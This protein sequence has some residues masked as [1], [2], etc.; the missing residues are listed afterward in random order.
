MCI[1]GF[2]R[3]M[4]RQYRRCRMCGECLEVPYDRYSKMEEKITEK[5]LPQKAFCDSPPTCIYA[6]CTFFVY[7]SENS[8]QEQPVNRKIGQFIEHSGAHYIFDFI[9]KRFALPKSKIHAHKK[10]I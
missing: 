7:L 9:Q 5:R 4:L 1:S 2:L 3:K 6:L 8:V 10:R